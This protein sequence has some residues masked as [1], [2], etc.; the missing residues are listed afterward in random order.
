[1]YM[2]TLGIIHRHGSVETQRLGNLIR[3]RLLV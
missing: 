2:A 3:F 1:M